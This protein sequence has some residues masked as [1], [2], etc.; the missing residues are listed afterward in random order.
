MG[1]YRDDSSIRAVPDLERTDLVLDGNYRVRQNAV[2]KCAI[3]ARKKGFRMFA[4]QDH[5]RCLSSA[6]AGETFDKYGKSD[7]CSEDGKGGPWAN[8]VYAFRGGEDL[9]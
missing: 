9:F 6:T 1:C 7:K 3:V 4:I 2:E 8:N 5:G